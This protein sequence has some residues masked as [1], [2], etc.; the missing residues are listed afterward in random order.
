MSAGR[1]LPCRLLLLRPTLATPWC[2]I[3]PLPLS[4]ALRRP[5]REAEM[6]AELAEVKGMWEMAATLD[7]FHLFK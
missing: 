6:A 1:C 4:P 7:F 5:C 3:S 2:R